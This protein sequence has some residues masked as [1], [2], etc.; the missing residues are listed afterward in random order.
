M[1]NWITKVYTSLLPYMLFPRLP[2]QQIGF[3]VLTVTETPDGIRVRQDRFL[4]TGHAEAK[5]NETI[6]WVCPW[7]ML[8]RL[9]YDR[10]RNVPLSLLTVGPDGK[11]IIDRSKILEEREKAFTVD[12]TKP[13][14]L[15]SGTTGVC[16]WSLSLPSCVLT[17]LIDHR[18][19]AV[20]YRTSGKDFSRSCKGKLRVYFRRPPGIG[21][22]LLC[23]L[24]SRIVQA[25]QLADS[26]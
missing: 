26:N 14:K 21:A 1:D 3:P 6:W 13:F 11:A 7:M 5:D 22:R 2:L 24:Q 19:S 9:M 12:T 25:Q 18:P 23:S 20:H 15:N 4:E 16:A 8:H 17:K 10:T